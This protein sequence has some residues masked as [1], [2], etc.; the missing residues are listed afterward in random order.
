MMLSELLTR[1]FKILQ[2]IQKM[3]TRMSLPIILSIKMIF[4]ILSKE[5]LKKQIMIAGIIIVL[6]MKTTI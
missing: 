1:L 2:Y 5:H 4:L 6:G 3:E